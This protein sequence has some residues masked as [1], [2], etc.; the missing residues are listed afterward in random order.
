MT[1]EQYEE[2]LRRI[3]AAKA[4]A[5]SKGHFMILLFLFILLMR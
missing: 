4:E 5:A 1:D 2:L 3:D